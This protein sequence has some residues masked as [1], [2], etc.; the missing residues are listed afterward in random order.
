MKINKF[1]EYDKLYEG[2]WGTGPLDNDS[3]SNWKFVLGKFIFNE[4][5]SHIEKSISQNNLLEIYRGVG[6]WE[7]FRDRHIDD[8]YNIFTKN[9]FYDLD[10]LC[11]DVSDMLLTRVN[12]MGWVDEKYEEEVKEYLHKIIKKMHYK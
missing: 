9:Q 2:S 10:S 1:K 12:N 8:N 6:M 7:Y 3:A 4:I 11:Y 5:Y